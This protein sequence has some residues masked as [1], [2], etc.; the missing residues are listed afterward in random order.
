MVEI[1][2]GVKIYFVLA[3]VALIAAIYYE[4]QKQRDFYNLMMELQTK[5]LNILIL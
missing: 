5:P 3:V 4:N 1:S 2:R